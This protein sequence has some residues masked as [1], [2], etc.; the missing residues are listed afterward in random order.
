MVTS[1]ECVKDQ[2]SQVDFVNILDRY[3]S[4][5]K[6]LSVENRLTRLAVLSK[7]LFDEE[8]SEQSQEAILDITNK[9]EVDNDQALTELVNELRQRLKHVYTN[10]DDLNEQPFIKFNP[11]KPT[12]RSRLE[13]PFY[14]GVARNGN[15]G[16]QIMCM[17]RNKQYFIGT[18]DNVSMAALIYD[19][20]QL[21]SNG[22]EVK[23]NLS[24]TKL[25][26]IAVLS[27]QQVFNERAGMDDPNSPERQQSGSALILKK[28]AKREKRLPQSLSDKRENESYDEKDN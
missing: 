19:M 24:Y 8:I 7:V 12:A 18:V 25:D 22:L 5:E 28:E 11:Q 21:Q 15:T 2:L 16:W 20:I 17:I 4:I 6:S 9:S 3:V 1:L 26:I 23:T 10:V 27:I 14:R 13:G